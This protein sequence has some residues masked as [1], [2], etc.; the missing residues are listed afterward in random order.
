MS[1]SWVNVMVEYGRRDWG[2]VK[3]IEKQRGID[4]ILFEQT[5]NDNSTNSIG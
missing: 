3:A 1:A 5:M 4:T 2:P